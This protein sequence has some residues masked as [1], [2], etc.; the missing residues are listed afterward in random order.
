MQRDGLRGLKVWNADRTQIIS[1]SAS[2]VDE[3]RDDVCSQFGN[4]YQANRSKL[5]VVLESDGAEVTN[6]LLRAAMITDSSLVVLL[7]HENW[8]PASVDAIRVVINAIPQIVCEAMRSL[9]L[10][11]TAPTWKIMEHKGRVTVVLSWEP[12][13]RRPRAPEF[14]LEVHPDVVMPQA[15]PSKS[16][17]TTMTSGV[18]PTTLPTATGA[19]HSTATYSRSKS[20]IP[21]SAT[22]PQSTSAWSQFDRERHMELLTRLAHAKRSAHRPPSDF[23][24]HRETSEK[25][26]ERTE[27]RKRHS[28]HQDRHGSHE[29]ECDFHCSAL[30][31]QQHKATLNSPIIDLP[32]MALGPP[33]VFGHGGGGMP[34]PPSAKNVH[35]EA[36]AR[37]SIPQARQSTADIAA[38]AA[39]ATSSTSAGAAVSSTTTTAAGGG[40][41]ATTAASTEGPGVSSS[42]SGLQV[43]ENQ[44]NNNES[45]SQDDDEILNRYLLLVDDLAGGSRDMDH[46]TVKDIG[47]ILDLLSS[48]VVDVDK[49]EREK[50][51]S[52]I[53]NWTIKAT[54][55]GGNLVTEVGL[56]YKGRYICLVDHP[57]YFFAKPL[58]P[59]GDDCP[60]F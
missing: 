38:A 52:D 41:A 28:S 27:R 43:P 39:A 1:V 13:D 36:T 53:H 20:P 30:H 56:V 21:P 18:P 48:R 6:D 54:I 49:L 55:R 5:R 60:T 47:A 31:Q 58:G 26:R 46:L 37:A 14:K 50:E 9:E 8:V 10:F 3:L 57:G 4:M 33:G 19:K 25:D 35:F 23:F 24:R 29:Q 17:T 40:G 44:R 16:A 59:T 7:P 45:E 15:P 2:T 11:N 42:T 22:A 34:I 32:E 51:T 12:Q